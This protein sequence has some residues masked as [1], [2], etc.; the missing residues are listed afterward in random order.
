MKSYFVDLH[1]HLGAT[2]TGKPVKI[3]A[4]KS[5]TLEN[6]LN[7]AADQKGLGLIGIIDCHVPEVLQQLNQLL[8]AGDIYEREEGG[9]CYKEKITLILGSELEVYDS[10]SKGPIHV[11]AFFPYLNSMERFSLWLTERVTNVNL[12]T[13]RIYEDGVV[14]QEQVKQQGGLFIPA[15]VFTPFKSLY[16]KGVEHSI[17]EVFDSRMIDGIELGLSSDTTM[18][19]QVIELQNYTFLTNSDAHSLGNIAREYQ[20]IKMKQP[21]FYE[22]VKALKGEAGREIES[23]FGLNPLLGKYYQTTCERCFE[24]VTEGEFQACQNC[25][26]G[27]FTKGV[28]VRIKELANQGNAIPKRKR[29]PYIHQIPLQFIPTLGPKTLEKLRQ[30]FEHEM[31][32]IHNAT[33]EQLEMVVSKKIADYILKA[34]AGELTFKTGGGGKYGKVK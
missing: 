7:V 16:G 3:T 18:A 1:I 8:V 20:K 27:Q 10:R 33:K 13:Q 23:N 17:E 5:M 34:R 25:G 12:S 11:L 31:N 14:L 22:L 15:H 24:P 21:S 30:H 32:I 4:S 29:P 9:L 19:N 26:H 6:V 2:A 28:A